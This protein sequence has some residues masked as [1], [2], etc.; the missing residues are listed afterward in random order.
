M[1]KQPDQEARQNWTRSS[2]VTKSLFKGEQKGSV[3]RQS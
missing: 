1:L 2:I 3:R